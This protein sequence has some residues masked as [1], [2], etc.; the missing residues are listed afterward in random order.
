MLLPVIATGAETMPPETPQTRCS[1]CP[2]E[3]PEISRLLKNAD[4]L[5]DQ[6]KPREAV[7]ELLKV[8]K[9]EPRHFEAIGKLARAYM[10]TGDMI[11]ETAP[12]WQDRRI[13]Q[14]RVAE[15]YGRKALAIDPNSTWGYF[16]VAW[17]LGKIALISPVATQIDLA[18]EIRA[19]VEKAIALDS[20]NGYAYHIYGVWQRRMA[21]IGKMSR[22]VASVLYGRSIP[23]GSMEKSIE[24]LRKAVALNPTM[25]IS[26]L[27]L[28]KTYMATEN[29][30]EARSFL[31]SIEELPVKFSD[32][33]SHKEKARQLV[34]EIRDR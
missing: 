21:E 2:S 13:K 27:E 8:L 12:E 1:H 9:L 24:Y 33:Q 20:Q 15:E 29:W 23:V 32:D 28:G 14:Y 5:Y 30:A 34:E 16:Y 7:N 4:R 11:P 26:R 25:I 31:K 22:V 6:F 18:S 3:N 19:Y 10:D 17:S